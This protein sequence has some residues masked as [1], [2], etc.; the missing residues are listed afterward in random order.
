MKC[1][2]LQCYSFCPVSFNL[3]DSSVACS[4][5]DCSLLK[6]VQGVVSIN[7]KRIKIKAISV[8]QR[9]LELRYHEQI[10]VAVWDYH[11]P[12]NYRLGS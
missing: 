2:F 11:Y 7:V 3:N 10:H 6:S 12:I 1:I 8:S 9:F 4:L 5:L